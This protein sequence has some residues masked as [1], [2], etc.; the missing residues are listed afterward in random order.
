MAGTGMPN[1]L[2]ENRERFLA[3]VRS[4]VG[5]DAAAEEIL[6]AAFV[7]GLE[8]QRELQSE[9]SAVAWF[10]RVLRN[11]IVDHYRHRA[12][13]ARVLEQHARELPEAIDDASPDLVNNVCRCVSALISTLKPEQADVLRRVDL[14]GLTVP[15]VAQQDGITPNNAAVRLHRARQALRSQVERVCRTCATHGC[16]DCTC[17][18]PT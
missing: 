10:Y 7:K 3:F 15:A 1:E 5:S 13:E 16:N 17:R 9:E 4:R 18:S 14:E 11:A 8:A 6:Q 12:A 2:V